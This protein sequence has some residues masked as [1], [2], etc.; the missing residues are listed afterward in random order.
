MEGKTPVTHDSEDEPMRGQPEMTGNSYN[1]TFED[2]CERFTELLHRE[3][4]MERRLKEAIATIR[5]LADENAMLKSQ[6]MEVGLQVISHGFV[7]CWHDT[8]E[9]PDQVLG[10]PEDRQ[11]GEWMEMD[12]DDFRAEARR[13]RRAINAP[14]LATGPQGLPE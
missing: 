7:D 8:P 4:I 12:F 10:G 1:V 3:A 2:A 9:C 13:V 11:F 5:R 6:M 14:A